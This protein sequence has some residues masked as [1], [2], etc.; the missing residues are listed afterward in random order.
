V[1]ISAEIADYGGTLLIS[2]SCL[3]LIAYRRS[4]AAL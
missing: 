2:K 4:P 3:K 1:L